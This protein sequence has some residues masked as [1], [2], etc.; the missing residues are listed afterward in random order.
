MTKSQEQWLKQTKQ[1]AKK[2]IASLHTWIGKE[3]KNKED[4]LFEKEDFI[5]LVRPISHIQ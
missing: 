3:K 1:Q 2:A 5:Q 4:S